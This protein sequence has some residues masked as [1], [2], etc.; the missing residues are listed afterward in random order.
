[1]RT[2]AEQERLDQNLAAVHAYFL[3]RGEDPTVFE[4]EFFLF[5][6]AQGY[7]PAQVFAAAGCKEDRRTA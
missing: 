7:S 2:P 5:W 3:A 1:M 6:I 4:P